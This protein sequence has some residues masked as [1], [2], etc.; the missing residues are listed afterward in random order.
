MLGNGDGTFQ[1]LVNYGSGYTYNSIAVGDFNADGRLDVVAADYATNSVSVLLGNG[2][3]TLQAPTNFAV[4]AGPISV[5]VADFNGDGQDDILNA[6]ETAN[7]ISI[8]LGKG[9]GGFLPAN[10]YP[11]TVYNSQE[12]AVPD[13]NGDE[14]PDVA[15]SGF[16]NP[17]SHHTDHLKRPAVEVERPA[18]DIAVTL[19]TALP[20]VVA[21]HHHVRV[22]FWCGFLCRKWACH[23]LS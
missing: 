14:K 18:E 15:L 4:G 16:P 3:G 7:S 9:N 22:P 11:A 2:N 8:L 6:N 1:P 10:S 13:L 21:Q 17:T 20:E 23:C 12:L 19:E 5:A